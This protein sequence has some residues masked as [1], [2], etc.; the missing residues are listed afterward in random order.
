[1]AQATAT[2]ETTG[3][4]PARQKRRWPTLIALGVGNFVDQ[5]EGQLMSVL[6][7]V[8]QTVFGLSFGQLGLITTLRNIT[9]TVSAPFWG[10]AADRWSRRN[11][12]IFGTGIWGLWTMIIGLVDSYNQLLLLRAVSGLGLGCLMPATFSVLS[13]HYRENERGRAL[14]TIGMLGLM[15]VV[16]SVVVLGLVANANLWRWGFIGLGLT[17]VLS[18]LLIWLLVEEPPRGAAESEL[19]GL[20]SHENEDQFTINLTDMLNTLRIPTI[21]IAI[22]QGVSGTMP[23]VVMG[24]FLINWMIRHLGYSNEVDLN[25]PTGSA[26]L[27]F[28]AIVV[29]SAI[30]NLMGGFIG[31]WADRRSP[32]YGRAIIG[33]FSVFSGVPLTYLLFSRGSELTF[34]QFFGLA[35]GTALLIGWAG[36]GAKEPMMAAVV[37][38]ELRSSGFSVVSVIEGGL[39][40]F[41]G[42]LAGTLA[43]R[44]GLTQALLWT[45]PFPWIICGLV[46]CGFYW[47]YPRDKARMHAILAQ[48]RAQLQEL[49]GEE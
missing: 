2:I 17:S 29:G 40:A 25:A 39:S 47:S 32:R 19:S 33:Q 10:Y 14:G 34:W 11:V 45:I 44:I 21:W 18:G 3:L 27:V 13:D 7:P 35:F 41:A 12:L 15:G 26:P 31:D 42:L 37:P 8:I 22:G 4:P 1:M 46:F 38:P 24:F 23:W 28:A 20:I 36:R 16:I 6:S 30:S 9:Q 5:G 48:H 49:A 43:D